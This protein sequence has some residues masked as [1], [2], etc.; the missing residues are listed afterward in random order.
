MARVDA[1]KREERRQSVCRKDER[2][3]GTRRSPRATRDIQTGWDLVEAIPVLGRVVARKRTE[4]TA[5]THQQEVGVR[6][7]EGRPREGTDKT[8]GQKEEK[9]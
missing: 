3:Q 2:V 5:E 1:R 8:T 4:K 9:P 6:G 7:K